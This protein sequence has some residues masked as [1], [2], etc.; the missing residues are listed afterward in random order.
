MSKCR[1]SYSRLL[2]QDGLISFVTEREEHQVFQR[3]IQMVPGLE[4]RLVEGSD[5]DV[6]HIAE[7]VRVFGL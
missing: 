3:L 6:A 5:E 4:D 7:L 2:V 1:H